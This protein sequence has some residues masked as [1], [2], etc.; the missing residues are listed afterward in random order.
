MSFLLI[1]SMRTT[2]LLFALTACGLSQVSAICGLNTFECTSSSTQQPFVPNCKALDG[3]ACCCNWGLVPAVSGCGCIN[4]P[5]PNLAPTL[6]PIS[7]PSKT[8]TA[9]PSF[10]PTTP[11]ISTTTTVPTKIVKTN[12]PTV[13]VKTAAPMVTPTAPILSSVAPTSTIPYQS[14]GAGAFQCATG[15][16]TQPLVPGCSPS[17]GMHCCCNWGLSPSSSGCGC[18]SG[19]APPTPAPVTSAPS[20]SHPPSQ[21]PVT[22][23]PTFTVTRPPSLPPVTSSP[24]SQTNDVYNSIWK[25]NNQTTIYVPPQFCAPENCPYTLGKCVSDSTCAYEGNYK[26][27]STYPTAMATYYCDLKG[28]GCN[29]V[30]GMTI[31]A[32][33][34]ATAMARQINLPL[35]Y[36]Q[37]KT[38]QPCVGIA[39]VPPIMMGNNQLTWSS[40]PNPAPAWGSGLSVATGW[41]YKLTGPAGIA[42]VAITD[43]CGGYCNCPSKTSGIGECGS[44]CV[45]STWPPIPDL[46]PN[47]QCRGSANGIGTCSTQQN[48][49]WC[50]ANDHPH[51]D[52]DQNTFNNICGAAGLGAGSCP[53]LGAE[54]VPNCVP[55]YNKWPVGYKA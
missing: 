54:P 36:S 27:L 2:V 55:T 8:S 9:K 51:F 29:G 48:C 25:I 11:P 12:A 35:C 38:G 26:S 43:R 1:A 16:P 46:T 4:P 20:V 50:A 15:S 22:S 45:S 17:P 24:I 31:P 10:R 5:S 52:L 42:Y 3:A 7:V 18:N 47:C 37:L 28:G 23:A 44:Q 33:D 6:A 32:N 13:R 14:C 40:N 21:R 19:P 30:L 34:T 53:L 39:A 41:C 49:D